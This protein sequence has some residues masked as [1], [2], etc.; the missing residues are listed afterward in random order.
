MGPVAAYEWGNGG[1]NEGHAD[2]GSRGGDITRGGGGGGC[3]L[4][5]LVG[6]SWSTSR[7]QKLDRGLSLEGL[8]MLL[9]RL[10]LLILL[11]RSGGGAGMGRGS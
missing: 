11:S 1:Y 10:L 6:E 5:T 3:G 8:A 7:F 9:V 2:M 4:G